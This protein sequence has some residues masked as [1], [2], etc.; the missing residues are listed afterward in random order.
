MFHTRAETCH[1]WILPSSEAIKNP[2]KEIPRVGWP[3]R[4]SLQARVGRRASHRCRFHWQPGSGDVSVVG[5]GSLRETPRN[6][7]ADSAVQPRP[8]ATEAPTAPAARLWPPTET[9]HCRKTN[10]LLLHHQRALRCVT[11]RLSIA[12]VSSPV[13][14]LRAPWPA[15]SLPPLPCYEKN[16]TWSSRP[17]LAAQSSFL[18]FLLVLTLSSI[19]KQFHTSAFPVL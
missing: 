8:K 4:T 5:R 19:R 15:A 14:Y 13:K 10:P 18:P 7:D 2:A 9:T 16:Y 17:T 6:H 3:L 12:F 1:W 11:T